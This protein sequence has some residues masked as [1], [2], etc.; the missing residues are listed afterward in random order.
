MFEKFFF[1]I[2][3]FFVFVFFIDR[4]PPG[5]TEPCVSQLRDFGALVIPVA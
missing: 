5:R 2:G 4:S 3:F 1:D